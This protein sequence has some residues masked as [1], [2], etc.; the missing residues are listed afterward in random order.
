MKIS[1][2]GGSYV[3]RSVIADAQRCVNLYPEINPKDAEQPVTHLPTPGLTLLVPGSAT[4][5]SPVRGV[6]FTTRNQLI[7][8]IGAYVYYVGPDWK[9]RVLGQIPG[10][11]TPVSMQDNG[12]TMVLVD[13]TLVGYQ[14]DLAS[15]A[16]SVIT[17]PN[18][19]GADRFDYVDGFLVGNQPNS[20]N[21]YSSLLNEVVFDGTYIAGK[22][23][24]PDLLVV[25]IVVHR[26]IWLLG[27]RTSEPWYN[28][29]NPAFPFALFPGVFIQYGCIAK[30][31][32]AQDGQNIFWLSQDRN[33]QA[34]VL[35]GQGYQV[36]PVTTPA[37][38]EEFAGYQTISD[39][40]GFCYQQGAHSFYQLSFPTEDKTWVYDK[41]MQMWHQ[42]SWTDSN[43]AEHRHR[44]NCHTQAY[45]KNVVG[46]WQ[47][48]NLYYFDLTNPTDNGGNIGRRRGLPH[49][50]MDGKQIRHDKFV[51]DLEVGTYD[52]GQWIAQASAS[53]PTQQEF[54]FG[55][56]SSSAYTGPLVSLRW[57]DDR[58]HTWKQPLQ[59]PL[60]T[61]GQGDIQAVWKK[62]GIARDRVYEL[63]WDAPVLAAIQG[64]YI[65]ATPLRT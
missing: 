62:L 42:R 48:G 56:A 5:V 61:Q 25:A 63:Y 60:G 13:G 14:L 49:L 59:K 15:L 10:A 11:Q 1:L 34:L 41:T 33:G 17:D 18:F 2:L 35:M 47:N 4:S 30:Y 12:V 46:D 52:G 8:V 7:A 21:F 20:Q 23:S 26:E 45:G 9:T 57:S 32:P 53:P 43:G 19:L 54:F 28:A 65:D 24:Y 27:Q 37:I 16:F 38:A 40:V 44:A 31:S 51:A 64:A 36:S 58:G 6:Y 50:V 39:A 55:A 3:A 22:T 29:G